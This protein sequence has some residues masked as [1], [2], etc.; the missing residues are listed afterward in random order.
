MKRLF[1]LCLCFALLATM[2]VPVSAAGSS[3]VVEAK[4]VLYD[5]ASVDQWN[6]YF[7]DPLF[8]SLSTDLKWSLID[9]PVGAAG[10]GQLAT[11]A[12]LASACNRFMTKHRNVVTSFVSIFSNN[13]PLN[14]VVEFDSALG[15][16]R[17]KDSRSGLWIVARSGAFPYYSP[18]TSDSSGGSTIDKNLGGQWVAFSAV[19]W[20][21]VRL[22]SEYSLYDIGYQ[23][24]DAGTPN[25]VSFYCEKHPGRISS[26]I[27]KSKYWKRRLPVYSNVPITGAYKLDP[28]H[29]IG[30]Y[31]IV[32]GKVIIDEAGIEYNNRSFK[33]FPPEAIYWYTL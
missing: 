2:L 6:S 12:D 15:V 22:V 4:N 9:S 33:T 21:R 31:M 28:Q 7:Q 32:N 11:A 10:I 26:W 5:T 8:G 19:N 18:V 27:L 25:D 30:K 24:R 29:D 14:A 13:H 16:Y 3:N 17:L 23:L 1:S 20:T